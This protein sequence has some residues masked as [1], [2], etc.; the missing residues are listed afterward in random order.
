[1]KTIYSLLTTTAI[2]SL[3]TAQGVCDQ[4]YSYCGHV[5][6]DQF[7]WGRDDLVLVADVSNAATGDSL[8][9]PSHAIFFCSDS[10]N[11][12]VFVSDCRYECWY[13]EAGVNTAF[14]FVP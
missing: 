2:L 9:D 3:A 10:Y 4:G 12:L 11:H 7:G 13:G 1:M 5:L 14:C 8:T 6:R